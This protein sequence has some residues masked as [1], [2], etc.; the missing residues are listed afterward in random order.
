MTLLRSIRIPLALFGLVA[1]PALLP[2]LAFANHAVYVEGEEDFD[3][4]NRIGAAED[5][6]GDAVFGKINTALAAA[7][8]GLN[9]NGKVIIVTSGR[10]L[11][12]VSITG[13]VTLEGAPG[14]EA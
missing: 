8:G 9:Q 13:P 7:A 3:R 6:D 14:V 12:T 2:S 1:A 10:F 5:T 4:D 11:E